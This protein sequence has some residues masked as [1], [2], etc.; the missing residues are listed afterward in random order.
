MR[1]TI[2]KDDNM[3]SV[4]GRA[5][6]VDCSDL[7]AAFHALQWDGMAGEIEYA[8]LRCEH[9]GVRSK[10]GNE[11]ITDL[12][13]YQKYVDK[14]QTARVEAEA[15]K[16]AAEMEAVRLAAEEN[17][18]QALAARQPASEIEPDAAG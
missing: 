5:Y 15:A 7:P 1:V 18:R 16:V 4:D 9:C 6:A 2:V 13:P 12:A 3:V 10:K 11:T 17:A 14:W 8:A